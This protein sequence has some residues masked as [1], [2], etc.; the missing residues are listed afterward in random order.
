MD[1]QKVV[2]ELQK[3][4]PGKNI[5]LNIPEVPTEIICEIEP[6]DWDP[7]KSV[8]VAV[9]D[10]KVKHS[11]DFTVIEYQVI[12]GIL[13]ITHLGKTYFLSE[14]QK[15]KIDDGEY[16]MASG[17]ETWVKITSRPAWKPEEHIISD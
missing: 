9:L 16:H 4:Y 10:G 13:E 17:K 5:V 1:A 12:K 7:E 15:I 6:A 14:G 11:H 8:S 2:A 3:Q